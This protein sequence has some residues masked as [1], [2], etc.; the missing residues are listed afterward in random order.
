MH[1]C[2]PCQLP[3]GEPYQSCPKCAQARAQVG[4]PQTRRR[5]ETSPQVKQEFEGLSLAQVRVAGLPE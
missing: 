3:G 1:H 5:G 2:H 4:S